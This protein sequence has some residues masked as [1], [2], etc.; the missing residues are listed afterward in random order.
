ME[1]ALHCQYFNDH[2][3]TYFLL[4]I[5]KID[6]IITLPVA[7]Y[8]YFLFPDVPATTRA[9]YFNE[10]EIQLARS[11]VPVVEETSILSRDFVSRVFKLWYF[12]GFGFLWILG[13][14]SESLGNQSLMNLYLKG[15]P[16]EHW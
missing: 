2:R 9:P 16:E 13:N 11:R 14:C 5:R 8:G 7:A 12:Y 10:E 15:H 1:M 4:T 6:G 3:H